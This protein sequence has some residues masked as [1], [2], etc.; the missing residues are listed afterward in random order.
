MHGDSVYLIIAAVA[1]TLVLIGL[2][3]LR[4][5]K[6][7]ISWLLNSALIII[8]ASLFFENRIISYPMVGAGIILVII[9]TIRKKSR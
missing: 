1:F 6:Q 2:I 7:N 9:D 5:K 4:K 3:I 8:I